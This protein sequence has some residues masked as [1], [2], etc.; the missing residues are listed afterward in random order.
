MLAPI[1]VDTDVF[2]TLAQLLPV[3]INEQPDMGEV[4][5]VPAEGVIKFDM[6]GGG[7]KPFL[8]WT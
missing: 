1:G 3:G 5:R 7:N 2:V 8:A 4:W 6:L